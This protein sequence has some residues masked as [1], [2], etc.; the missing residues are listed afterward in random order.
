MRLR[1]AAE[2][3]GWS[4]IRDG[5]FT[6]LCL[7]SRAGPGSLIYVSAPT[8][9]GAAIRLRPAAIIAAPDVVTGIPETIAVALS[10]DPERA[11]YELH[12]RLM[13]IGFYWTDAANRIDP[14]ARINDHAWIAPRNVTIGPGCIVEPHATIHERVTLGTGVIIRSGAVIGAEG[15]EFKGPAMR[16]GRAARAANVYEGVSAIPHAGS[17]WIGDRAE[18]QANSVVDRSVFN[19]PTRIGADSK[20]DNLVQVAHNVRI[21][22]R[23][24]V[25][26]G[27]TIA[28]SADIGDEVWIGPGAVISSGVRVGDGAAVVIG[29]TVIRDVAAGTRVANDLKVYRLP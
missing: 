12:T 8:L 29:T 25:A 28:G 23:T 3:T 14:T 2:L 18:V 22:E 7:A 26:A 6:D 21:G 13:T 16:Q 20:L 24:L 11:F 19:E 5:E 10:A 1:D 17:V 9:L 15:F 4:V 27:A